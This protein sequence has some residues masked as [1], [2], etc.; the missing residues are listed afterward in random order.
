[1]IG[2][3]A[4]LAAPFAFGAPSVVSGRAVSGRGEAAASF[5]SPFDVDAA[6][7]HVDLQAR[8]P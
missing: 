4:G 7:R 5:A 8:Q 2:D 3:L 6:W 1:M